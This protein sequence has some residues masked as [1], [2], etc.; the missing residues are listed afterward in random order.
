M[1]TPD[2]TVKHERSVNWPYLLK[3][4]TLFILLCYFFLV[5]STHNG[6]VNSKILLISA[7]TISILLIIGVISKLHS[8]SGIDTPLLIFLGIFVLSSFLSIDRTRSFTE[9]GLILIESFILLFT[10]NLVKSGWESEL[11]IKVVIII[12]AVFMIFS[13]FEAWKWYQIWISNHPGEWIPKI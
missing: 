5:A 1:N 7:I 9:F 4:A 12:G 10:I 8:H 3:E 11:I 2:I 13:W 6:L